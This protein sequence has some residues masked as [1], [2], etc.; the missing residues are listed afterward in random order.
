MVAALPMYF[1]PAGTVDAFWSA[2]AQRL[3]DGPW[4]S[5]DAPIPAQLSWPSD[6]HAHWAGGDFLISQTCGYPLTTALFDKVQ[7]VGA[8]SYD[9]AGAQGVLCTSQLICRQDDTRGTLVDFQGCTLAFNATDSQSGYNALRAV[10]A[11]SSDARPFF[12][13][14]LEVGSHANAIESVR[15]GRADLA[16]IDCVTL[17]LWEQSN[18]ALAPQIRVFGRTAPYPGLPLV[19]GLGTPTAAL[20]ALR[21]GLADVAN[22]ARFARVRAPLLVCGF[23]PLELSDYASCLE[24]RAQALARGVEVL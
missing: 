22:D 6:Y 12:G 10:V 20:A 3:R 8:F 2:L 14:S 1:P 4:P 21:A 9:V 15:S 5:P 16:A 13:A 17:A 18:P 19:T 11:T 23:E 24:M 7:V